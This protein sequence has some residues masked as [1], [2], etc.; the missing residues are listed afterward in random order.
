MSLGHTD[1][2]KGNH[3]GL[4]YVIYQHFVMLDACIKDQNCEKHYSEILNYLMYSIVIK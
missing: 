1:Y 3:V 4:Q 2:E